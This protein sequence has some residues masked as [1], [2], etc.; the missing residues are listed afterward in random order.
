MRPTLN[1]KRLTQ[2][3]YAVATTEELLSSRYGNFKRNRQRSGGVSQDVGR[4][5]T[6][7]E[8]QRQYGNQ[9]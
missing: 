9:L 2:R 3:K 5:E 6:Q 8:E 7:V 4:E 1:S